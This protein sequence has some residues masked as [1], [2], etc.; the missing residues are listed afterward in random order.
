M[1]LKLSRLNRHTCMRLTGSDTDRSCDSSS[2]VPLPSSFLTEDAK[3]LHGDEGP[4]VVVERTES[5]ILVGYFLAAPCSL[6]LACV[7]R[8]AFGVLFLAFLGESA[9]ARLLV[10]ISRAEM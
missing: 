1:R 8:A 3:P 6:H 7:F 10:L 9:V 5:Q 4:A 2:G